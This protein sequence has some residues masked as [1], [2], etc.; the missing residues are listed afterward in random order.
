IA[1]AVG[2]EL[3]KTRR[4]RTGWVAAAMCLAA[5]VL[6]LYTIVSSPGLSTQ[7]VGAWNAL[8]AGL[9][10]GIPLVSPLLLAV[11]ASRL[12]DVE[13]QGNGWLLQS[14]AGLTPGMVCRAKL[15]A[16]GL[17][18]TASTLGTVVLTLLLGRVLVGITAP[19]PLGRFAGFAGCVLV[20]NLAVLALHVLLSARVDNQL[21]SLGVGALGSVVAVFSQG[22]P[23]AAAHLTPW[24]Y[25]ALAKAA[26]YQGGTFAASRVSYPSVLALGAVVGVLFTLV[27]AR[28]DRQEA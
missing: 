28:F 7:D 14:T 21:V 6:A 13:H 10:L 9:S 25:Y 22:L 26:D 1:T 8:L 4:L 24:G 3:A 27:T 11:L 15:A 19:V 20:V 2:N 17:V 5:A 23:A 18:V 16:L 12:V